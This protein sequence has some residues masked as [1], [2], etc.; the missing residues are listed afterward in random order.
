MQLVPKKTCTYS[1]KRSFNDEKK[2][3]IQKEI[4]YYDY[5]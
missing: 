3:F 4:I 2:L 1:S 5:V